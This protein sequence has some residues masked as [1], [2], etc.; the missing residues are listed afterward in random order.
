M[1]YETKQTNTYKK[2]A[3]A[4]DAMPVVAGGSASGNV[5]PIRRTDKL[6]VA[7][8]WTTKAAVAILALLALAAVGMFVRSAVW[9]A[10]A[11]PQSQEPTP[12][13]VHEDNTPF[14]PADSAAAAPEDTDCPTGKKAACHFH[15]LKALLDAP[16]KPQRRNAER[17]VAAVTPA[18]PAPSAAADQGDAARSRSAFAAA[19]ATAAAGGAGGL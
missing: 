6:H 2:V 1:L 9:V 7:S 3:A 8:R 11:D 10:E 18:A 14:A 15:R 16:T 12:P 17:P 19:E 13:Q 4:M 5:L